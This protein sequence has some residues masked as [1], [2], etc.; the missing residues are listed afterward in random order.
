[1]RLRPSALFSQLA[2]LALA[3]T[4]AFS[5][6]ACGGSAD[7]PP[8]DSDAAYDQYARAVCVAASGVVATL[9][10]KL[11]PGAAPPLDAIA[12]AWEAFITD[13]EK[14]EPPAGLRSW[15]EDW[16]RMERDDLAKLR[17]GSPEYYDPFD[18]APEMSAELQQRMQEAS[19]RVQECNREQPTP[20]AAAPSPGP[21]PTSPSSQAIDYTAPHRYLQPGSQSKLSEDSLRAIRAELSAPGEGLELA[22]AIADWLR[23]AFRTEPAGGTTIGKTDVNTLITSRT[24]TGCHDSALV[25][26]AVLR[27]SGVPAL[28]ADTAAIQW[29]ED[30]QAGKT[31]SFAGHVFVEAYIAGRWVLIECGS[32]TYASD[33]DPSNP[34]IT[35]PTLPDP[36]GYY[37]IARGLD[38]AGYDVTSVEV[39]NRRMREFANQLP[40]KTL[41]FPKYQ[42]APLNGR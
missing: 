1:M 10:P 15:H 27:S 6:A 31:Q 12:G 28:M 11:T 25:M 36:K 41:Q 40:S 9:Q 22:G 35:C 16:L 32:A 3:A 38:P 29:A 20:Q 8:D 7:K 30:Y 18:H 2:A 19:S 33:Y 17:A 26:S 4:F 24:L 14:A 23:T 39:L 21:S 5:L 34:V 42:W 13:L 37:V